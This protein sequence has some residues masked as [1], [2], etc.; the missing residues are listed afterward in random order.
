MKNYRKIKSISPIYPEITS[1]KAALLVAKEFYEIQNES[2][3]L[4][5]RRMQILKDE[6]LLK[7]KEDKFRELSKFFNIEYEDIEINPIK[8]EVN[9]QI[10]N[11]SDYRNK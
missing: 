1:E 3:D 8:E 5:Q 4:N 11:P 10:I 9:M 2:D 7:Q 6:R